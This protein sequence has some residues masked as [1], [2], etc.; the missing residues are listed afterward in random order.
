[1]TLVDN[2]KLVKQF[3]KNGNLDEA[4]LVFHGTSVKGYQGIS[5]ANFWKV[6]EKTPKK[7]DPGWYGIGNYFATFP[8][9]SMGYGT[10][11]KGNV[12][13]CRT[14]LVV[15]QIFVWPDIADWSLF[16]AWQGYEN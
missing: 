8:E 6:D 1:M 3:I 16:V 7:T 15:S 10:Q 14:T 13:R 9:Y 11:F 12:G 4:I 5:S 2:E